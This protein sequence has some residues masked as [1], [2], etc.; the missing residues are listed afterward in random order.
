MMVPL[1]VGEPSSARRLQAIAAQ[2]TWRKKQSRRAWG[3]GLA[4]S[5]LVQRLAVRVAGRQHVIHIHV[6]NV[7]GPASPLYLAGARLAEAFPVVPLSGNVTLG[8][9]VLSYAGQLNI[10][11]IADR[12]TCPDLP[13]FTTGLTRSLAGLTGAAMPATPPTGGN[14]AR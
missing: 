12:D 3:T 5:P 14:P 7:P 8:I 4:G 6:A 11:V 10:T 13:V 9:G 1:P 2:T